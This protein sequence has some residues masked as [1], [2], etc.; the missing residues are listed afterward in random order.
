MAP[1]DGAD[2]SNLFTLAWTWSGELG[3]GEVF[4]VKVCKG[5]VC[6]PEAGISN[7]KEKTWDWCPATGEGDYRWEVEV[8]DSESKQPKGPTSE[9]WRFNWKGKCDRPCEGAGCK[10]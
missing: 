2:V 5:E 8:I 10:N 3:E 1:A 9:V 7:T 6:W 4:D